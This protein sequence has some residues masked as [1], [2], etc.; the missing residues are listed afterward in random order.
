MLADQSNNSAHC[1]YAKVKHI[2]RECD[3][4]ED[5]EDFSALRLLHPSENTLDSRVDGI[6]VDYGDNTEKNSVFQTDVAVEVEWFS[7]VIPEWVVPHAKYKHQRRHQLNTRAKYHP[8]GKYRKEAFWAR[9]HFLHQ[10]DSSQYQYNCPDTI[11]HAY[12]GQSVILGKCI[13]LVTHLGQ[14]EVPNSFKRRAKYAEH[15]K[16]S[17]QSLQIVYHYHYY[18]TGSCYV[19]RLQWQKTGYETKGGVVHSCQ[20]V[21]NIGMGYVKKGLQW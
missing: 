21:Y 6:G 7:R 2:S 1:Q 18:N 16:M 3:P 10:G 19:P 20:M 8:Q 9:A 12:G 4:K 11:A 5:V 14:V 15:P 17:V 13:K